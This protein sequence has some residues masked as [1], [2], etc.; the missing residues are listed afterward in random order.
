[1]RNLF[2]IACLIAAL[3][4][5]GAPTALAD[6]QVRTDNKAV[7]LA[8]PQSP[9]QVV[10]PERT[11]NFGKIEGGQTLTH[12]FLIYNKGIGELLIHRVAPG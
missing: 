4:M 10:V 2:I 7:P 12:D 5:A 9:P 6:S 11:F 3:A 8:E 1:M